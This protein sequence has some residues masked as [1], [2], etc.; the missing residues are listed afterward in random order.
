M[1]T[2]NSYVDDFA[3]SL[4]FI[5]DYNIWVSVFYLLICLD[6]KV[7]TYC[8]FVIFQQWLWLIQEPFAFT[9]PLNFLHRS[10]FFFLSLLCLLLCWF[11]VKTE[12][13]LTTWVNIQLSLCRAYVAGTRLGDERHFLLHLF[14]VFVLAQHI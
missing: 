5:S 14:W 12:H 7:T 9:F 3:C 8:A 1:I 11:P 13:E 6:C 4:F 2:S 10:K